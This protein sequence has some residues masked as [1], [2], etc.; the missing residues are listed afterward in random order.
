MANIGRWGAGL[1]AVVLAAAVA[2][3]GACRAAEMPTEKPAATATAAAQ[4][5]KESSVEM[6]TAGPVRCE[7]RDG[8]LRYLY[9]D[10]KEIVRR[11]YFAVR[12]D[13]WQTPMPVFSKVDVQ[14]KADSFKVTLAAACKSETVDYAWTGEIVGTA[15]G[16]ITFSVTGTPAKTF[17][18][19][20]IGICVLYG[21]DS[22]VGQEFE[23][24]SAD[25]KTATG[26]WP[27]LVSMD[28][29]AK[30][31]KTLRYKTP[32]GVGVECSLSPILFTMED[33]RN[34]GDSSFKAYNSVLVGPEAKA[35]EAATVTA[36][37][38]VTGAK[39]APAAAA[40]EVV[41]VSIGKEIPGAKLPK[42]IAAKDS[43]DAG[44]FLSLDSKRAQLK[45]EKSIQIGYAP[46][47]HL[48]DD[49]T[50]MENRSG[51]M[52]QLKTLHAL[53]PKAKIRVDPIRLTDG[54]DPRSG[55]A[56]AAAWMIG[57]IKQLALGGADEACFKMDGGK[58]AEYF[59]QEKIVGTPILAT[60]VSA[61]GRSSIEVLALGAHGPVLI[62]ASNST[63]R[64]QKV[65]FTGRGVEADFS[66]HDLQGREKPY[67]MTASGGVSVELGPYETFSIYCQP[68][69]VP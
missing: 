24:V 11:I 34:Y 58:V 61:R 60:T 63:D 55:G 32:D 43:K 4:P 28:L 3:G 51:L 38:K 47:S 33:Q 36:T 48:P 53:A 50:F 37:L 69:L 40:D 6:L 31:Y 67:N 16:T 25:G 65:E 17:K 46:S 29:V 27:E 19:N 54:D 68:M 45:D 9:V 23:T 20:R 7:F 64:T 57:A 22:L 21:A 49:D 56:F 14:K 42:I 8:Q 5:A 18:S 12:D 39:P 44:D 66:A 62:W 52:W 30:D 26:K 2:V 15:D 35:G 1:A 41:R 10:Q 13:H 59:M